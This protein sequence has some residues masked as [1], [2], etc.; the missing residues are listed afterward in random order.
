MYSGCIGQLLSGSGGWAADVLSMFS[1]WVFQATA[2][3]WTSEYYYNTDVH[4]LTH[5]VRIFI[6]CRHAWGTYSRDNVYVY[7]WSIQL[8]GGQSGQRHEVKIPKFEDRLRVWKIEYYRYVKNVRFFSKKE[9]AYDS[10]K[11]VMS[12]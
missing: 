4:A 7:Q 1:A 2:N 5:R 12:M 6:V 10:I 11:I 3:P 8:K 9:Y